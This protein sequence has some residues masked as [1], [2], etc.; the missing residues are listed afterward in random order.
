[1]NDDL[2]NDNLQFLVG[3]PPITIPH[4]ILPDDFAPAEGSVYGS[5]AEGLPPVIFL[6]GHFFAVI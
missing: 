6:H 4:G 5:F 3:R 2:L 1:M